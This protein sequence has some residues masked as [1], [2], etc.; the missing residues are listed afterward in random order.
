MICTRCYACEPIPS[1]NTDA[2]A[3]H[4][5]APALQGCSLQDRSIY[6]LKKKH[7]NMVR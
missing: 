7:G 2:P 4:F 3:A 5:L 1:G 6:N